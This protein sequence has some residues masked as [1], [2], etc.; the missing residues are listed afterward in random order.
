MSSHPSSTIL[1]SP[2]RNAG[3]YVSD[4]VSEATN[5]ASKETNKDVAKDSNAPLGTRATAG[6]DALGDKLSQ[7]KDGVR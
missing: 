6:K 5:A 1:T 3:N 4:K 2:L 7:H